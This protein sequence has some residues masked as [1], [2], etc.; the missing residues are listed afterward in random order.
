MAEE[1]KRGT[2][3]R[4]ENVLLE[5]QAI[6]KL[7]LVDKDQLLLLEKSIEYVATVRSNLKHSQVQWVV[8]IVQ[9]KKW[10]EATEWMQEIYR[11]AVCSEI[12]ESVLVLVY[13]GEDLDNLTCAIKWVD[14][15]DA[16]LRPGAFK[17]LYKLIKAKKH[18][19]QPQVLLLWRRVEDLPDLDNIQGQLIDDY[20]RIMENSVEG[21]LQM[22][23][24]LGVKI[25]P[26]DVSIL[27][28]A[29]E[30]FVEKGFDGTLESWLPLI[31]FSENLSQPE[32]QVA[33]MEA[34]T[35]ALVDRSLLDSELAL[36]LYVHVKSIKYKTEWDSDSLNDISQLYHSVLQELE[37]HE[38]IILQH[39]Q[40]Y[41]DDE[42]KN[43]IKNLHEQNPHLLRVAKYFV[44]W[45]FRDM[46]LKRSVTLLRAAKA[47][48]CP[49][50][51]FHFLFELDTMICYDDF[52]SL[53]IRN[54]IKNFDSPGFHEE[55]AAWLKK[56]ES[57]PFEAPRC[58]RQILDEQPMRVV[59][60]F[61]GSALCVQQQQVFCCNSLEAEQQGVFG[62]S[63]D[64]NT[65]LTTFSIELDGNSWELQASAE[66]GIARVAEEGTK[67]MFKTQD[68]LYIKI[69]T[70][71]GKVEFFLSRYKSN[72]NF[73]LI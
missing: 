20:Y 52:G 2:V 22:D 39:Y 66:D 5:L 41:V 11:K 21:V 4:L 26:E 25:S 30:C 19:N 45:Y 53:Y 58:F 61:F 57:D 8:E 73:N 69:F 71:E 7:D 9:E 72:F 10:L 27:K 36:T 46:D 24:A 55:Y 15:L 51:V 63:F 49:R 34:L 35:K 18:I 42:D 68:Q 43:K 47:I 59:N 48:Q 33:M 54:Q 14:T 31:R 16:S 64:P 38:D 60:K 1:T 56:V 3:E 29:A 12:V 70:A 17:M 37:Q 23:C 50:V 40:Q 65:A 32:N 62:A 13:E 6:S 44:G 28:V 67:W